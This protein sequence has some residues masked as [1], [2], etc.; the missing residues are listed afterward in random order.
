MPVHADDVLLDFELRDMTGPDV[1]TVWRGDS[2]E[3]HSD[4]VTAAQLG[5]VQRYVSKRLWAGLSE[6]AK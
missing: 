5:S 3:A 4:M 2:S 1:G 6:R